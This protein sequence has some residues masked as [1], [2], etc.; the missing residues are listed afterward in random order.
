M[1]QA[2][3]NQQYLMGLWSVLY[4]K[5]DFGENGSL[6]VCA[7]NATPSAKNCFTHLTPSRLLPILKVRFQQ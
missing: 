3:Q 1:A 2:F 4:S 7:E 5:S 6:W